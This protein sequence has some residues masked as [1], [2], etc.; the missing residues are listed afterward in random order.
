MVEKRRTYWE[1]GFGVGVAV[2]VVDVVLWALL[3]LAGR[4]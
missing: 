2:G 3:V 4:N 1:K